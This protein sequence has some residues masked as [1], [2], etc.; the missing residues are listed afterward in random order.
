MSGNT[1]GNGGG[2]AARNGEGA[3]GRGAGGNPDNNFLAP[4]AAQALEEEEDTNKG[5]FSKIFKR[6]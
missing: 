2:A 4:T 6:G 5:I 1:E 3:E